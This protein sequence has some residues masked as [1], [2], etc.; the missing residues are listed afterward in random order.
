[1]RLLFVI[2]PN[3]SLDTP[4]INNKCSV[5]APN[6][7]PLPN[8]LTVGA[9][10]VGKAFL[11]TLDPT[12]SPSTL[13][14][15]GVA[16]YLAKGATISGRAALGGFFAGFALNLILVNIDEVANPTPCHI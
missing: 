5:L 2:A 13:V 6:C 15:T 1:V 14:S 8:C 9:R 11:S 4:D 12:I 3:N 10:N 7:K 16:G